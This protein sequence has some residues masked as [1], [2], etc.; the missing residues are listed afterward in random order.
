MALIDLT[1]K[2]F[3][4]Q[5]AGDNALPIGRCT[6]AINAA[7]ATSLTQRVIQQFAVAQEDAQEKE[8]ANGLAENLVMLCEE[9]T[10]AM[11]REVDAYQELQ[12]TYELPEQTPDEMKHK[13]EQTQKFIIIST[14]V[15]F[16]IAEMAMRMMDFIV[17][18]ASVVDRRSKVE[19][20]S[21]MTMART[22]VLSALL[23]VK[24]NVKLLKSK[25]VLDDLL[26][27]SA[28]IE[29]EAVSKEQELLTS[30]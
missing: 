21:A 23:V 18:F 5:T 15:S 17:E 3:L 7:M 22:A 24:E 1:I 26:K 20:C 2:D 9:F 16:D 11:D 19:L 30:L 29:A 14:M 13:D 25:Q 12:S 28:E 27:K 10:A 6:A 4:H 8:Q